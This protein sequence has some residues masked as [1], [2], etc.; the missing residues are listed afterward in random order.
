[1]A[2][3]GDIDLTEFLS[4][5]Y[6]S[7]ESKKLK[8]TVSNKLPWREKK[9]AI[10]Y[11]KIS[12][13]LKNILNN[14]YYSN[15]ISTNYG[16]LNNIST[17]NSTYSYTSNNV[18]TYII[19]AFYSHANYTNTSIYGISWSPTNTSDIITSTVT[20]NLSSYNY[21]C[22]VNVKESGLLWRVKDKVVKSM[23]DASVI[24][25]DKFEQLIYKMDQRSLEILNIFKDSIEY[26]DYLYKPKI[27]QAS[28]YVAIRYRFRHISTGDRI[29]WSTKE[30][31]I[32]ISERSKIPW[33]RHL[34]SWD[35]DDYMKEIKSGKDLDYSNYLKGS[36][37]N[38]ERARRDRESRNSLSTSSSNV[39]ASIDSRYSVNTDDDYG[40]GIYA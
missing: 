8:A 21:D 24:L 6:D 27:A 23:Y 39:T 22:S 18:N 13:N 5:R 20:T 19:N 15:D 12:L 1:M 16:T 30:N 40:V 10:E 9:D 7:K 35:Y 17:N 2:I 25:R 14:Y 37:Y 28:E 3:P 33:L 11:Y 29:P 38:P 32:R 34:S 4:F 26:D 36:W 31:T